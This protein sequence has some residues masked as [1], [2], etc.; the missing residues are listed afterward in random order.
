MC[1]VK[2]SCVLALTQKYQPV[3]KEEIRLT[4]GGQGCTKRLFLL[5]TGKCFPGLN[6]AAPSNSWNFPAVVKRSKPLLSWPEGL[7]C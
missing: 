5:T 6:A 4:T 2:L 7:L 1:V 3:D